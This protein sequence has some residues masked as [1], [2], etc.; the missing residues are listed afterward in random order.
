M[1]DAL[2]AP[3]PA[4]DVRQELVWAGLALRDARRTVTDASETLAM[5]LRRG[6]QLR[7]SVSEMAEI[8]GLSRET[9]YQWTRP[10]P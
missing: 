7:L 8:T 3:D 10:A 6:K 9:V 5:W 2:T 1:S 4:D